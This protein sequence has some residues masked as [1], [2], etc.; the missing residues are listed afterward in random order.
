MVDKERP[1]II[2]DLDDTLYKEITY[3][4]SGIRHITA[5]LQQL[6]FQA[7]SVDMVEDLQK[8]AANDFLASIIDLY[9][10][11]FSIKEELLWSYRLHE[12]DISL[13][14]EN[15]NVIDKAMATA[16]GVG[17]ITDGRSTTQRLKLKSLGLLHLSNF[18]SGDFKSGKPSPEMFQAVEQLWP[19]RQY[20]YIADNPQKDFIAP[21]ARGWTTIGL[22]D[23]GQNIKPG[24]R[25]WCLEENRKNYCPKFWVEQLSEI[26]AV[27]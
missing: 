12:P 3:V 10:A 21:N 4:R 22:A 9:S 24:N 11:P 26:F 17:I 1:V 23:D 13:S 6:G 25:D 19:D 7:K 27:L 8:H 15:Q 14:H 2:F 18:V 20:V 16:F 5:F